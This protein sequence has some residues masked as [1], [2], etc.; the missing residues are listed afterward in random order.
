MS[1]IT[2]LGSDEVS[3]RAE[4]RLLERDS[5]PHGHDF[6]ELAMVMRGVG[7]HVTQDGRFEVEPGDL[8]IM[9]PGEWH[10]YEVEENLVVFNAYVAP[11]LVVR[12]FQLVHDAPSVLRLLAPQPGGRML[13]LERGRAALVES[14]L[15]QIGNEAVSQTARLGLLIAI[16]AELAKD[17]P[18]GASH[19]SQPHIVAD[20]IRRLVEDPARHWTVAELASLL[21]VSS[22]HLSR[23]FSA[24]TGNSVM[25]YLDSL[26]AER[27][28]ALLVETDLPVAAVGERVGWQDPNYTSRRFRIHFGL[29]PTEYRKRFGEGAARSPLA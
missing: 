25:A 23:T 28:A 17:L 3:I 13:H 9:R 4:V 11:E 8:V 1:R 12:C 24:I 22:S 26:R 29:T 7:V 19:G 14:W 6:V 15:I 21:Y 16:L 2:W 20:A 18:M 27:A 10:G 5:A